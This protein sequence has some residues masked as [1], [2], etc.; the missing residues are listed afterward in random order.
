MD[1]RTAMMK[2]GHILAKADIRDVV[3]AYETVEGTGR[4]AKAICPFHQ[5][6]NP[7]MGFYRRKD[8]DF[9]RYHC[10]VC[11]SDGNAFDFVYRYET[12]TLHHDFTWEQAVEKVAGIAGLDISVA[13]HEHRISESE[14]A[15]DIE[16]RTFSYYLHTERA[17]PEVKR[18]FRLMRLDYSSPEHYALFFDTAR[19]MGI[20]YAPD[21]RELK[22]KL[23]DAGYRPGY[24]PQEGLTFARKDR[25]GRVR[26]F[27][28]DIY[29]PHR[30][31]GGERLYIVDSPEDVLAMHM[32]G[33]DS[34][35]S[36]RDF[37]RHAERI[38]S[39][40]EHKVIMTGSISEGLSRAA[41]LTGRVQI[42]GGSPASSY[43]ENGAGGITHIISDALYPSEFALR[44]AGRAQAGRLASS[45]LE[46]E[47]LRM[48]A[49]E[50]GHSL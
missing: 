38:D 28:P 19:E 8:E 12:Q 25:E 36:V 49:E 44:Y 26:G 10:F 6:T 2:Y 13:R 48:I 27:N 1:R 39:M 41:M 22:K 40:A 3:G 31:A 37:D 15:L 29:A 50:K 9:D 47:N 24:L 46:K 43:E 45:A 33:F 35:I 20:G 11:H 14:R 23:E 17:L 16:Q 5:D 21:Y 7:S 4:H 32:A 30:I 18:L 42:A 34:C